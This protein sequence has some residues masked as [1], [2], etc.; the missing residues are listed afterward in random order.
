MTQ[1]HPNDL[2]PSASEMGVAEA[3]QR[4]KPPIGLAAVAG[5][6]AE[7]DDIDDAVREIYQAR[8]RSRDR[9]PPITVD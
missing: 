1:H 3:K 7:W 5:A 2:L 9:L 8:R 6:L 4:F